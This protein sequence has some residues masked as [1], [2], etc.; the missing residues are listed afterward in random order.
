MP[1]LEW[2]I[3]QVLLPF[4]IP[5]DSCGFRRKDVGHDKDLDN[6]ISVNLATRDEVQDYENGDGNEPSLVNG[7]GNPYTVH[8]SVRT[9]L[10]LQVLGSVL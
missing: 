4:F 5:A 10:N 7:T 2:K 6:I 1:P 3:W 9:E 8:G